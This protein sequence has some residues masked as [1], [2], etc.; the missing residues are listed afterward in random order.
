[1]RPLD[2]FTEPIP[3][4]HPRCINKIMLPAVRRTTQEGSDTDA[5]VVLMH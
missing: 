1:M 2:A 4:R 3:H 5:N